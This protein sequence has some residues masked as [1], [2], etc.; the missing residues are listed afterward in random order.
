MA[1]YSRSLIGGSGSGKTNALVNLI[2]KLVGKIYLYVKD[3]YEPKYQFLIKKREG[4]GIKHLSDP[5][6]CLQQLQKY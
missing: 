3:L 2:K 4:A 5:K 6:A 1:I